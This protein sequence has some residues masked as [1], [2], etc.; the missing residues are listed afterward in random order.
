MLHLCWKPC[1]LR[2]AWAGF[3]RYLFVRLHR[4]VPLQDLGNCQL[5]LVDLWGKSPPSAWRSWPG[6]KR[7]QG[8]RRPHPRLCSPTRSPSSRSSAGCQRPGRSTGKLGYF[9]KSPFYN[10]TL[11]Q[12]KRM[13]YMWCSQAS[14]SWLLVPSILRRE[15]VKTTPVQPVDWLWSSLS[16]SRELAPSCQDLPPLRLLSLRALCWLNEQTGSE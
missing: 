1:S 16:H 10:S 13:L 7:W 5:T 8:S 2:P 6:W 14:T 15:E 11:D 9:G 4:I 3:K 12:S